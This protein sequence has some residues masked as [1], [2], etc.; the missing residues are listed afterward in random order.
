MKKILLVLAAVCLSLY[1][2]SQT[3]PALFY[4][5]NSWMPD[6]VGRL[7]NSQ[8]I[9]GG[10]I[11][12][13]G[14]WKKIESSNVKI[15]RYGGAVAN[16]TLTTNYQYLQT[17][18]SARAHGMEPI[19]QVPFK[20]G[21][22]GYDTIQAKNIL[23]YINITKGKNVKYWIIGNE[24]EL[25]HGY[26][27][28]AKRIADY[29]KRIS[30]AMKKIDN[31]IKIIGPGLYYM[32]GDA[33]DNKRK[34]LDTLTNSTF[35]TGTWTN[36]IMGPIPS[37]NGNAT[38]KFYIDYFSY[39][40]YQFKGDTAG[41]KRSW[42]ISRLTTANKDTA[43]MGYI[44]R[45]CDL[46]NTNYSRGTQ[47]V[48]PVITEA[49][50]CYYS[51]AS[52]PDD[53]F[54]GIKGNSFIAGQYWAELMSWGIFKG[55]QFI[56]FWS[57]IEGYNSGYLT[58]SGTTAYKKSTYLH[59]EQ[60]GKWFK[61]THYVASVD[62]NGSAIDTIKAFASVTSSYTAVM[63]LNQDS[64]GGATA[65]RLYNVSLNN[66][67]NGSNVHVK[68]N[69][70][71][72]N[73]YDDTTY[74]ASTNLLIFDC[75]GSLAYR[76]RYKQSD[77]ANGFKSW[78][79]SSPAPIMTVSAGPDATVFDACCHTYTVTI[80]PTGSYMKQWYAN[81]SPVGSNSINYTRCNTDGLSKTITVVVTDIAGCT[82]Q[83]DALFIA[84]NAAS[85]N[86]P[87]LANYITE[88]QNSP[89]DSSI[90]TLIPNPANERGNIYYTIT[91]NASSAEI[92]ISNFSGQV[93]AKYK[94]NKSTDK[95][96]IDSSLL[97]AGVYFTTLI[98][99]QK[100][101]STKK[102]VITK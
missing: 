3:T 97:P 5:Q 67:S 65:Y 30:I 101:V 76:Y 48:A 63:I 37:G 98:V 29:I 66:S 84:S 35:S 25:E 11:H 6:S 8:I 59:Q 12:K 56:N 71:I 33:G 52:I 102:L 88:Q 73:S 15:I 55:I 49:N 32:P 45:R 99:D 9:L 58:N 24:P 19:L 94:L 4:G 20:P 78:P 16:K 31:T 62:N 7:P 75:N 14:N 86:S 42:L 53:K 95:L 77:S 92:L 17:V 43:A 96:E 93:I 60:M 51:S 81:G 82:A 47:P 100:K 39:H 61:G 26:T 79:F 2:R 80:T 72:S 50:L 13:N 91:D 70:G 22:N 68:I 90:L 18:D 89:H 57:C 41:P 1:A 34:Q 69:A 83:D 85:C 74:A 10:K 54:D 64:L 46:A 87:G 21:T 40:S 27:S 44:K 38:G 36:T 23:T 28:D